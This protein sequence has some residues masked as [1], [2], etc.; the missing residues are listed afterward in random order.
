MATDH[1]FNVDVHVDKFENKTIT[2]TDDYWEDVDWKLGY[3]HFSEE[4]GDDLFFYVYAIEHPDMLH[5]KEGNVVFLIDDVRQLRLTGDSR[6]EIVEHGWN[7][8]AIYRITREQVKEICDAKTL[9][10]RITGRTVSKTF[11]G[12]PFKLFSQCFYNQFF[13][14]NEYREAMGQYDRWWEERIAERKK[15]D[16]INWWKRNWVWIVSLSL[17]AGY[18]LLC[19]L[20]EMLGY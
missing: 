15:H 18:L 20:T 6:S 7:E 10:L 5:L 8:H 11:Q 3:R 12:Y 1:Y 9:E 14:K 19:L 4:S 2:K 13:D 17:V 16:R